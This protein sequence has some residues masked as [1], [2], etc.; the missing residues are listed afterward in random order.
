M[1]KIYIIIGIIVVLTIGCIIGFTV[2]NKFSNEKIITEKNEEDMSSIYNDLSEYKYEELNEKIK[3]QECFSYE[4]IITNELTAT[5]NAPQK[6]KLV[7]FNVRTRAVF[8]AQAQDGADANQVDVAVNVL[9]R[10][11]RTKLA[12][13]PIA[14]LD[15]IALSHS[16]AKL[17]HNA[18]RWN[19]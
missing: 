8:L 15:K 12:L 3:Y 10:R 6:K 14:L 17:E 7:H 9:P 16:D 5:S 13:R 19:P 1:K 11:G 2:K 4:E 18:K